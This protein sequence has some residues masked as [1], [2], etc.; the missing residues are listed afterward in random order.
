[1]GGITP[2][3]EEVERTKR[4]AFGGERGVLHLI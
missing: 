4:E 1:M 2:E 3:I